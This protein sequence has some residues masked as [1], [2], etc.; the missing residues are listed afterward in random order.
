VQ[1]ALP[2]R[3]GCVQY[4]NARPLARGWPGQIDFDHPSV[5]CRR[6]AAGELDAA[7]VSS[8][9]F[10]RNPIYS[11]VDEI[12]IASDGPVYSV[13][14]AHEPGADFAETEIDPASATGVSLLRCLMAD[15]GRSLGECPPPADNL[16]ELQDGRGRLLIGDQAIRFRQ[17][18]GDRYGY[19]DLGE[20]WRDRTG[21]PFVF[22]LWLIRPEVRAAQEIADKLRRTRDF[23]LEN[24]DSII[25]EE[26]QFSP[27]F[28]GHYYCD[29]LGFHFGERE[30]AGLELFRTLCVK[31]GLLENRE[32]TL[33]LV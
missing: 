4:L 12:A 26:K 31:Q 11:I 24:L 2:P 30:K 9:E 32:G 3:L 18:F 33:R 28:C 5:L 15:A 6:L 25:A 16:S 22:A 27:E 20:A 13:F 19:W 21:A 14:V 23:N 1:E 29:C 10:L 7:L 17:K 8:F